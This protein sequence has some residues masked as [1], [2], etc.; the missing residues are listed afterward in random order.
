V[1]DWEAAKIRNEAA[2]DERA[3]LRKRHTST[4]KAEHFKD[5]LRVLDPEGWLGTSVR[6]KSVLCLAAG[7]GLASI[8]FAA[9]GARV[10]VVDIS[11]GMLELDESEA[12]KHGF[13][14]TGIRASMDDLKPVGD[15]AYD[16]VSQPVST[17]YV[18]DISKVYQEVARVIK[19]G[20]LYISMH[21]QPGSLQADALPSGGGYLVRE[22]Y[23][24]EGALPGSI[25]CLHRESDTIE[26]LH[27]WEELIGAMCRSG[28]VI[29]DLR[30]P[31]HG[32]TK[33]AVGEFGHRSLFLPPYVKIKA[34]RKTAGTAPGKL[35]W[36]P[37]Q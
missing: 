22:S 34:V 1:S 17:C 23:Y 21:K 30:E 26:Y 16:V 4:A 18:P 19:P 2:W 15:S 32:D 10:T 24:R 7:G 27:R 28:F 6:E 31:N 36:V 14:I 9:A 11:E 20:G 35:L 33:A 37:G 5:P 8:L 12:R 25:E 3:R 13:A 29:E